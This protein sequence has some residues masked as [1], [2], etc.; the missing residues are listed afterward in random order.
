MA[1]ISVTVPVAE[2]LKCFPPLPGTCTP[3]SCHHPT[4]PTLKPSPRVPAWA[5][6]TS[7]CPWRAFTWQRRAS[8]SGLP[9]TT[10]WSF[11]ASLRLKTSLESSVIWGRG[12]SVVTLSPELGAA[13]MRG[14]TEACKGRSHPKGYQTPS[15]RLRMVCTVLNCWGWGKKS[16]KESIL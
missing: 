6:L 16:K 12:E 5:A 10:G 2:T 7:S 8:T 11:S 1:C 14:G 9:G 4:H 3:G 13:V 15:I